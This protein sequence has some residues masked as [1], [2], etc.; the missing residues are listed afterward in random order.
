MGKQLYLEAL[1]VMI[2][3]V[4]GC[5]ETLPD[6]PPITTSTQKADNSSATP[7]G[8]AAIV[9]ANN[10][11]AFD[12][13]SKVSAEEGNVFLSPW[14]ISTA[15]AMVYEGARGETA[16]EM[17]SVLHF[18]DDGAVVR[19]SFAGIYNLINKDGKKYTLSTANALWLQKDYPFLPDYLSTI[20]NYYVGKATN[21]D[22]IRDTE[23]SRQI[24]NTWVEDQTNDKIKD[25]FPPG[26]INELTRLVL[27]NAIYFKGNWLTQ[28]DPADTRDATFTISPGNTVTAKMM[29]LYDVKF[30][31]AE[32]DDVQILEMPYDGEELSMLVLLP[33]DNDLAS[34][35][36]ML[37]PENLAGWRNSLHKQEVPV[38]FPKFT[39]ETKYYLADALS[40]MGMPLVFTPNEAD[41]SGMDGTH[42]LF[43]SAVI[44]QAFVDV[45]EEG[46]EA[47][48]A[49]GVVVGATS[50]PMSVFRA[51]HPFI[52]M[53]LEKETGSILFMGR[54][55]DPTA[56]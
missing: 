43:V 1:V 45:N 42:D 13:Y 21:L 52:F 39:F 54:V 19:S 6:L 16:D 24:I 10:Q 18:P 51:D 36:S 2:A 3:L 27:T 25:L 9:D 30:N 29:S 35:E 26:S 31:Y 49:T 34:V 32:T 38:Y 56:S 48:A 46:T 33:K 47:A 37:T 55:S 15:M 20:E 12:I 23:N 5:L 8:V 41:L 22:F 14:S 7:E 53:I 44:H 17:R 4:C 28:F 40:S 11:F 50:A